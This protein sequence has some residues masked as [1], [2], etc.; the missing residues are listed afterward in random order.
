MPVIMY[1]EMSGKPDPQKEMPAQ[2]R[3]EIPE[4]KEI[5][6]AENFPAGI[7]TAIKFEPVKTARSP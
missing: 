1:H 4:R 7:G 5:S 6:A 2:E 3:I